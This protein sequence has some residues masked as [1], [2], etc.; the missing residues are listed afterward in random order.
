MHWRD[1]NT[2]MRHIRTL[3][4]AKFCN[5]IPPWD[6]STLRFLGRGGPTMSRK[7]YKPEE[8]VNLLRQA[9]VLHGQGLSMAD[10]IRSA[11]DQR[12][13]VLPLAQGVCRDERR[14]APP[15]QRRLRRRINGCTGAVSD[16]TL[17]K[18]I[19]KSERVHATGPSACCERPGKLL[20]YSWP[21]GRCSSCR[22]SVGC[23]VMMRLV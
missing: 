20:L 17:D 16:L 13:H 18:Q 21:T 19:L 6:W 15:P 22:F 7:R 8:I 12:G 5:M 10:S 14:S 9:E 11:G 4:V 23:N 2:P 1:A 3:S